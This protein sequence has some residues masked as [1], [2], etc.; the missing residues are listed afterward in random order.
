MHLHRKAALGIGIAI[1]LPVTAVASAH[2]VSQTDPR[3]DAQ[4]PFDLRSSSLQEASGLR[5]IVTVQA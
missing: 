4:G 2:V 1:V 5:V 3:G